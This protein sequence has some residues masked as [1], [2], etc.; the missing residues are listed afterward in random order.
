M[1]DSSALL[2]GDA[3]AEAN[4]ETIM[5]KALEKVCGHLSM[6]FPTWPNLSAIP[7]TSG[8]HRPPKGSAWSTSPPVDQ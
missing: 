7:C 4:P 2:G 3:E 6:N 8:A 5:C 1:S